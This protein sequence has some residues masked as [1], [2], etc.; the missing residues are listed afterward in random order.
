MKTSLL[1]YDVPTSSEMNNPSNLL[2]RVALRINLSVWV[3]DSDRTPWTLLN[4]MTTAGVTWHL[5][6]FA[7]EA[8][9]NVLKVAADM[10]RKDL[11]D[12][13]K[14][15]NEALVRADAQLAEALADN[16]AGDKT[17]DAARNKH[18]RH[19][20]STLKRTE[21]VVRDLETAAEMFGLD[22]GSFDFR[23]AHDRV[24]GIR[25]LNGARA[26]SYAELAE[27]AKGTAMEMAAKAGDVPAG[28][29]QDYL[30]DQGVDVSDSRAAFS[31]PVEIGVPTVA[32]STNRTKV[33]GPKV[34]RT[35]TVSG[36]SGSRTVNSTL[37]DQE[38]A[39]ICLN[40]RSNFA[41][42]L[43]RRFR[44]YPLSASQLAWVHVLAVESLPK[45]IEAHKP[46]VVVENK[47][48]P[49]EAPGPA[50]ADDLLPHEQPT[51]SIP[52]ISTETMT[53]KDGVCTAK[54][55]I[56]KLEAFPKTINVRSHRTGNV[57]TF[58]KTDEH[59]ADGEVVHFEYKSGNNI[60]RILND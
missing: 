2:R 41:R 37:T 26:A 53:C 21:K 30:E 46:T 55:S 35:F 50:S 1:M 6:P 57:L 19:R 59:F 51:I 9:E 17:W 45:A 5:F 42:D 13:S 54:N 8:T 3:V 12:I 34:E 48:A 43:A 14:R 32:S 10:L 11:A 31:T 52:E 22:V 24:K 4:E 25:S 15:E 40:L 60:L 20:E 47:P 27:A 36:R 23:K 44:R 38:A 28:I 7:E 33:S 39:N 18:A 16:T 29:L 49:V 58:T 56:L